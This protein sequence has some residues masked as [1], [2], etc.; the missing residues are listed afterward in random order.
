MAFAEEERDHPR[1]LSEDSAILGRQLR[2]AVMVTWVVLAAVLFIGISA[3]FQNLDVS[4]A[5]RAVG[6][7][8]GTLAGVG[9]ALVQFWLIEGKRSRAGV[10][11]TI[12]V[13]VSGIVVENISHTWTLVGVAIAC[14]MLVAPRR[15]AALVGVGLWILTTINGIPYSDTVYTKLFVPAGNLLIFLVLYTLTQLALAL[16]AL[17]ASREQLARLQVDDERT[18]ISRDLHDILGRTLVAASL[19]N[20]TALQLIDRDIEDTRAQLLLAQET[21]ASGQAQL[22]RLTTGPMLTALTTELESARTMF[23]RL[24]VRF[25]VDAQK[26]GPAAESLAGAIVRE[27]V[28]NMLKH[29]SPTNCEIV[30]T[31]SPPTIRIVNDGLPDK[32]FNSDGTGLIHIR[33]RIEKVGGH[34]DFGPTAN[35]HFAVSA[36]LAKGET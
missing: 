20:Q 5:R 14:S 31:A 10:A 26:L 35:G 34:F 7:T 15:W 29:S 8:L 28:T 18:R 2:N 23:E 22:R 3:A 6:I 21:L 32:A 9:F 25:H 11:L 12:A 27:A 4:V 13:A 24:G 30:I 1:Q 33:D 36:V 17:R 19:R 16:K